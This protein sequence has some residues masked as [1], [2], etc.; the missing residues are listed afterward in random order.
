[1][2]RS[3]TRSEM[4]KQRWADPVFKAKQRAAVLEGM[5]SPEAKRCGKR[6]APGGYLHPNGKN[7]VSL[8]MDAEMYAA[9]V[10]KAAAGDKPI[11]EIIRTYVQWGLDLEAGE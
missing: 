9:V 8:L 7:Q 10:A 1:M 3:I 4:M 5:Y 2:S 11:G 6:A